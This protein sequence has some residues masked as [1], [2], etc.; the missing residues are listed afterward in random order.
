MKALCQGSRNPLA[1]EVACVV[2][3]AAQEV[4]SS[5]PIG[6][7][8]QTV[9]T[10]LRREWESTDASPLLAPAQRGPWGVVSSLAGPPNSAGSVA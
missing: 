5:F 7:R 8:F 10:A 6:P 9:M 3:D 2:D 1:Y 4:E